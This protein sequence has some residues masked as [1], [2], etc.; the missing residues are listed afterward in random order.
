[1]ETDQRKLF[2]NTLGWGFA[3]WLF[4]YVLGMLFFA[5]VPKEFIGWYTFRSRVHTEGKC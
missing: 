1:M 2:L 4:G 3:L 5:F